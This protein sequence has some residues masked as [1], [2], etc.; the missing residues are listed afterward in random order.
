[1][2][3]KYG[4]HVLAGCNELG[5][6]VNLAKY[7]ATLNAKSVTIGVARTSDTMNFKGEKTT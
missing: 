5:A 1:M 7:H 2:Y 3:G 4:I 6:A